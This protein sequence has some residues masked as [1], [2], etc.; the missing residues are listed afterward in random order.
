MKIYSVI[1][2]SSV[3]NSSPIPACGKLGHNIIRRYPKLRQEL[4]VP[5]AGEPNCLLPGSG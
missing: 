2:L 1:P 3:V 5:S 4:F